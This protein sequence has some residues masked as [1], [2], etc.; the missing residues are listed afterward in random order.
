MTRPIF[1]MALCL[2]TVAGCGKTIVRETIVERPVVARETVVAAPIAAAPLTCNYAGVGYASLSFSCQ[3]G[4][5]Y[6]CNNG[7]WERLPGRTC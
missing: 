6:Q 7:V 5:Q 3:A 2:V 1:A 4:V